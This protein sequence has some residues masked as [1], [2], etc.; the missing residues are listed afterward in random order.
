MT[1]IILNFYVPLWVAGLLGLFVGLSEL[2]NRYKSFQYVFNNLYSWIYM[3]INFLAAVLAYQV[4]TVYKI[5]LGEIDNYWLGTSLVAGLSAM[6]FLRSSF[7]NYKDSNDKVIEVGP[8]ALL[9]VFLKA[10][11]RQF[12]QTVSQV[13][14][15]KISLI[16]NGIDFMSASKDLPLI[17]L[18]S[19]RVLTPEEQK[20]LSEEILNLVKDNNA[21]TEAKSVTLGVIMAKYTGLGLL[22]ETVDT[23]K[24]IYKIK[25]QHNMEQLS[26]IEI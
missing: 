1:S 7:F 8:A 16:M 2:I 13:N 14:L 26:P 9:S 12:D 17:I 21:T 18:A 24:G 6:A 11:E 25:L 4:I 10:S 23:L 15:K 22:K 3:G 19:M 5:P 20:L